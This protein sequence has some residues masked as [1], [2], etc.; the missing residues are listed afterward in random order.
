MFETSRQGRVTY[1]SLDS[2]GGFTSSDLVPHP[3]I[4]SNG[5]SRTRFTPNLDGT[6]VSGASGSSLPHRFSWRSR[7]QPPFSDAES[8]YRELASPIFL[9]TESN[10]QMASA[11]TD[12]SSNPSPTARTNATSSCTSVAVDHTTNR[13]NDSDPPCMDN[14]GT[15]ID[16]SPT[17]DGV[18]ASQPQAD[19]Q[20]SRPSSGRVGGSGG[21]ASS[22]HS[23]AT[24]NT[25]FTVRFPTRRDLNP[26][27]N[28]S[29][30]AASSTNQ[31]PEAD[32]D[33]Y[34]SDPNRPP[35]RTADHP[36]KILVGLNDLRQRGQFCDVVLQAGSTRLPAHRNVLA[37]SSQYFYAMFTGP[38]A[39]ARSPCVQI[40]GIDEN[41][42]VQ[43]IDFIYTGGEF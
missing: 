23:S 42:L 6:S 24:D 21:S 20:D 43:L 7:S 15:N 30:A 37:S 28:L 33:F 12:A 11:G 10:Q 16:V 18:T 38:M 3:V 39:E 22:P 4:E 35:Y 17:G 27:T 1:S 8:A 32:H 29:T 31:E 41:A 14:P 34:R 25:F 13:N 2:H 26:S 19:Q 9:N 36:Q 40:Q 5:P